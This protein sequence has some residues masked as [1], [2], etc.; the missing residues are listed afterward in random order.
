MLAR[1][2]YCGPAGRPLDRRALDAL[3]TGFGDAAKPVL[4]LPSPLRDEDPENQKLFVCYLAV[5]K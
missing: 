5:V 4:F 2:G 1:K 3:V